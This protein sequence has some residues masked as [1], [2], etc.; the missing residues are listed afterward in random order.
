MLY[1]FT[2]SYISYRL[3]A[4]EKKMEISSLNNLLILDKIS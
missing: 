2:V 3:F 1:Y 4:Y